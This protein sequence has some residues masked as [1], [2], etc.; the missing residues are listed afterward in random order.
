MEINLEVDSDFL[1]F[2]VVAVKRNRKPPAGCSKGLRLGRT[3]NPI[4]V[5][6]C[7]WWQT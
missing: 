4:D 7:H 6:R 5:G 1:S 3:L 2:R